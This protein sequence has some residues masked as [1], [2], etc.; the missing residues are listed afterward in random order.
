MVLIVAAALVD[1]L[2]VPSRL[3]AG[4][5]TSPPRVAGYWE[6]PGGKVEPGEEPLA[7]LR[8]ELLEELGVT[9]EVGDEV[10][11]PDGAAWP[12]APSFEMRL[13][14][15]RILSDQSRS[16]GSHDA[17]RWLGVGELLEVPWL[18]ADVAVVRHIGRLLA[19]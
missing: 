9:V 2:A 19:G 5:R 4:R 6:F 18:P 10:V 11:N 8:R 7:G 1:D 12:I 15:A 16:D 17:L 3:L 13:W 14:F